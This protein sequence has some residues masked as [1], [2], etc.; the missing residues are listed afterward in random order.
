GRLSADI[1]RALRDRELYS[2][3]RLHL[4]EA[5]ASARDAQQS[6]L[7]DLSDRLSSAGASIPE[8]FEGVLI[9]N[10]LLDA[11]PVHQVVMRDDGLRE[12][13]VVV[14]KGTGEFPAR[15]GPEIHPS[16][17]LSPLKLRDGPPSTPALQDYLDRLGL[18]REPG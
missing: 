9:A 2:R 16:P 6:T 10:E 7:G 11:F 4:V 14:E 15:D 17:F 1:L 13:Y 8:L 12:M 5:S 3:V 18:T